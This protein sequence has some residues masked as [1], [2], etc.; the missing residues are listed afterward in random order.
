M[1]SPEDEEDEEPPLTQIETAAEGV[2]CPIRVTSF[3]KFQFQSK[4]FQE[5]E[6]SVYLL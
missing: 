6:H 5:L 1:L 2:P 3:L 4:N